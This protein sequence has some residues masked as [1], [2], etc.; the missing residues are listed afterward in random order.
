MRHQR[1]RSGED[2]IMG[3]MT[4]LGFGRS[5]VAIRTDSGPC[6]RAIKRPGGEKSCEKVEP[7]AGITSHPQSTSGMLPVS[8]KRDDRLKN[9]K[10]SELN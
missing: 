10:C 4:G 7:I 9:N 5:T 2:R 1:V 3:R 6:N 8:A